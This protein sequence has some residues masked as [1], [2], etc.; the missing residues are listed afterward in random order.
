MSQIKHY[1]N[2]TVK[3]KKVEKTSLRQQESNLHRH[4]LEKSNTK[5]FRHQNSAK[6]IKGHKQNTFPKRDIGRPVQNCNLDQSLSQSRYAQYLQAPQFH[7][8]FLR[9]L[10]ALLLSRYIVLR[11]LFGHGIQ[12]FIHPLC[13]STFTSLQN[14]YILAVSDRVKRLLWR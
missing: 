11:C 1:I 13:A 6:D 8:R 7:I 12:S 5:D 4:D 10:K 9:K 3:L 2:F 14:G